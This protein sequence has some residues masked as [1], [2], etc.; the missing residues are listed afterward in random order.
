MKKIAWNHFNKLIID[1][2]DEVTIDNR[3]Y[4]SLIGKK[5]YMIGET[6]FWKKI[7]IS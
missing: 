4:N 1:S 2:R 3:S 7:K 6:E 5:A